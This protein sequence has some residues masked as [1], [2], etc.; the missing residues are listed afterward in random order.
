MIPREKG[1][2]STAQDGAAGEALDQLEGPE[3]KGKQEMEIYEEQYDPNQE[4]RIFGV[5]DKT[6]GGVQSL[7]QKMN[8]ADDVD[9]ARSSEEENQQSMSVILDPSNLTGQKLNPQSEVL[10]AARFSSATSTADNKGLLADRQSTPQ[11]SIKSSE[12]QNNALPE[13]E[14]IATE[15]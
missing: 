2:S 15:E 6:K 8:L 5:G 10:D 4:F 1:A 3:S 14:E 13:D 9:S 11:G 7:Q 12:Q